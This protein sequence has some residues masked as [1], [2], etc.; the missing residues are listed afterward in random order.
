M[1]DSFAARLH[2]KNIVSKTSDFSNFYNSGLCQ[3]AFAQ[4]KA[5]NDERIIFFYPG[6]KSV[7]RAFMSENPFSKKIYFQ[8]FLQ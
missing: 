5:K 7:Q 2:F 4:T 3:C 8:H 6:L 1:L